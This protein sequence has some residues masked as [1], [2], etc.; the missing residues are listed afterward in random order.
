MA[1]IDYAYYTGLFGST[2]IA[3]ADFGRLAQIASDVIDNVAVI[4]FVFD[5]L[6]EDEQALVKKA[7]AYEVET[8]D[9]QGGVSAIVG[10]SS[11]SINSEQLGDYSI[12]GGSM[13]QNAANVGIV[14]FMQGIPISPLAIG[15]LRKAGLMNRWAYAGYRDC[16]YPPRGRCP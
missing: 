11:Q 9:S 7:T 8:L 3:Q 1:Y 5:E 15:L 4:E 14:P 2:D 12:S 16:P 10:Q 6:S 13:A